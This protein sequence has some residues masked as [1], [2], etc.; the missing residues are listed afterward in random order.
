MAERPRLLATGFGPFPGAPENPTEALMQALAKEP[1]QDFGASAF[2]AVVLATDYRRSWAALRRL[3]ASFKPDVAV[4]F[5][6]SAGSEALRIECLGRNSINRA[7]PDVS[8][9]A[10]SAAIVVRGGPA[11]IASTFAADAILAALREGGFDAALSDDA[12]L[13]VCNAT[14][15]R[16]LHAAPAGRRIGFVHVPPSHVLAPADLEKAAAIILRAAASGG[17]NLAATGS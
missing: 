9:V 5:G 11:A 4:H 7:K 10:P 3:H 12:G 16:S 8:G 15:Y 17:G 14:L 2:Q 1:P 6:L 13:Y